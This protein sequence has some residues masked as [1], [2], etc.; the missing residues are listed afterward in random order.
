M[1]CPIPSYLSALPY[2]CMASA[3]IHLVVCQHSRMLPLGI[4]QRRSKVCISPENMFHRATKSLA[5]QLDPDG[6][7]IPIRCPVDE[8]RFRPL[9]L[10]QR[11]RKNP[12][13][14]SN[15]YRKTEYRLHDILLSGD[16]TAR[17]DVQDSVPVT[18][19]DKVDGTMQGNI[20]GLVDLA[21]ITLM[22]LSN[23]TQSRSVTVKK[24][25]ISSSELHCITKEKKVDMCHGF[26]K[27][28][29]KFKR[30]LYVITE[31]IETVEETQFEESSK[32]EGSIFSEIYIK[33]KLNSAR[34]SKKAIIIPKDCILAFRAK[35]L[36]IK[37]GSLEISD[38]SSNKTETFEESDMQTD[39]AELDEFQ[40][41]LLA[42]SVEKKIVSKQLALVESI[43][44]HGSSN[45]EWKF[46]VGAQNISEEDLNITGAM[47]KLSGVTVEKN[48]S[49]LAGSGNPAAF[50]ALGALYVA[51]YALNL[52]LAS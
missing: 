33:V 13:W 9:C 24:I 46:D 50:S 38:Y 10:V 20:S 34:D 43:L 22:G 4:L 26:I 19:V 47:I 37:E 8:K 25:S 35:Q 40:L 41:S 5:K 14:Q 39:D 6:S 42:E 48:G 17:L 49:C 12:W 31:A 7:L 16:Q 29:K 51:L 36:Q 28:S 45:E 2:S 52:L 23:T 18:V 11:K 3:L 30:D 15:P 21:T 27:Q 44:D 1:Y 32:T